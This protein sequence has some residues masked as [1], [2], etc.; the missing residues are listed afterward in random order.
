MTTHAHAERLGTRRDLL[1]GLAA[2]AVGGVFGG[3]VKLMG[4]V[5]A[6]PR[7]PGRESPPAVAVDKVLR[8]TRGRGLAD[9]DEE[10]AGMGVHWA[11]SV[12]VSAAYGALAEFV[13]RVTAGYGTA[14]GLGVWAASHESTLP[15]LGL[16]PPLDEVPAS[17][18][19][20][21]FAS[22]VAYG[23][24]VELT[25]RVVRTRVLTGP[26]HTSERV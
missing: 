15:L 3:A 5:V 22:H 25:R 11:F 20:I 13:P 24:S 16:T 2:G 8:A 10:R 14:Y 18:Q 23:A 6:P 7:E 9:K 26:E 21:E 17:E 1:C 19:A 12:C 4:E